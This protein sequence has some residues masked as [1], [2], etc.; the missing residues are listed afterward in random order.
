[1]TRLLYSNYNCNIEKFTTDG[2]TIVGTIITRYTG[3]GGEIT[4]PDYITVIDINAFQRTTTITKI[5]FI[6][7]SSVTTIGDNAFNS[8]TSLKSITIPLSVNTIGTNA[9]NNCRSLNEII[10]EGAIPNIGVKAFLNIANSVTVNHKSWT[11]IDQDLFETFSASTIIFIDTNYE[12]K[13]DENSDNGSTI[14]RYTGS[15]IDITIPSIINKQ[16]IIAINDGAFLGNEI[17]TSIKFEN[18][19]SVTTIGD[20]AF[21]SCTSLKSI[22]IPSKVETIGS[23]AFNRCEA[24]DSITIPSKVKTIGNNAFNNCI[25]LKSIAIPESVNTI[26]DD[27]FNYCTS[28]TSIIVDDNNQEY[29]SSDDNILFN[30]KKQILIKYPEGKTETIYNISSSIKTIG[31]SA[32]HNCTSFKIITIPPSVET[33]G[34]SAFH[35]CTSLI[36]ITIPSNVTTIG[37]YAFANCELLTSII[38]PSN[39]TTIGEYAFASCKL[40][41]SIIITSNVTTI[42]EGAFYN[43]KSLISIIIPSSVITIGNGA[44]SNCMSL[45][46]III[47]SSVT[48]IGAEAFSNCTLLTSITIPFSV[49]T[50]YQSAFNY[51]T[52]LNEIIFEGIRPDIYTN[53]FAGI[54]KNVI[55]IHNGWINIDR[56]IFES[57]NDIMSMT[58]RIYPELEVGNPEELRL[59]GEDLLNP[60]SY[61]THMQAYSGYFNQT[62][63]YTGRYNGKPIMSYNAVPN[64]LSYSDDT[65]RDIKFVDITKAPVLSNGIKTLSLKTFSISKENIL[66]LNSDIFIGIKIIMDYLYPSEVPYNTNQSGTYLYINI[67]NPIEQFYSK[68]ESFE[69]PN[70]ITEVIFKFNSENDPSIEKLKEIDIPKLKEDINK[71]PLKKA[72]YILIAII[73]LLIMYIL[74]MVIFKRVFIPFSA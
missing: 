42:N 17:I 65:T 13:K 52:S 5:T 23:D 57:S 60:K 73:I 16:I 62:L 67:L 35:N 20:R 36:S 18:D 49:T 41:T 59:T 63:Q 24:L 21:L 15:D 54:A 33:I 30:N 9:F 61:S 2:L 12:I 19:S 70:D 38:I 46:S 45:T 37:K 10:F 32:F 51:C 55:V 26:G 29:S 31:N 28:L 48:T 69:L 68:I 47:P 34:N 50:I 53:A 74:Y 14:T 8:C 58:W 43:C 56:K 3:S 72:N 27:A 11:S 40:L 4:I 1:M 7:P 6:I 44:F 64:K 71:P 39:V 66:A 25:L 22:T